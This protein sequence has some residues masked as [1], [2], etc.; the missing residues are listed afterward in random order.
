MATTRPDLLLSYEARAQEIP[1]PDCGAS[2]T[3]RETFVAHR[4]QDHPPTLRIITGVG[5]IESQTAFGTDPK[6]D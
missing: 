2:F 1:C 6:P 4:E 3:D 5:G